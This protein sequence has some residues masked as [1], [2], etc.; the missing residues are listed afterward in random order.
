MRKMAI[1]R[2]LS[3]R[4]WVKVVDSEFFPS[5]EVVKLFERLQFL[6]E[7]GWRVVTT[8]LQILDGL[9]YARPNEKL[10]VKAASC[11]HV[12]LFRPP[13]EGHVPWIAHEIEQQ[14]APIE[15]LKIVRLIVAFSGIVA[16]S[17]SHFSSEEVAQFW[18]VLSDDL[19]VWRIFNSKARRP[20]GLLRSYDEKPI[21]I[22]SRS[23]ALK[24]IFD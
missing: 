19:S 2:Q 1:F 11:I 10:P 9:L 16:S 21:S 8:I 20:L 6:E 18:V 13:H 15:M 12:D 23:C 3:G 24:V 5:F 7:I 22:T 4:I 14:A 17:T